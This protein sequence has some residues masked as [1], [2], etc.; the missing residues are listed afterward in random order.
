MQET[1]GILFQVNAGNTNLPRLTITLDCEVAIFAERYIILRDLIAF[2]Q[3]RVGIVLAVELRVGRDV[4]V[5]GKSR[6]D[7]IG[8]GLPVDDR[9]DARHAHTNR[10]Y[11]GIGGS[12]G[13]AC[14]ART[15]HFTFCQELR[16]YFKAYDNLEI[17]FNINIL[18]FSWHTTYLTLSIYTLCI[19]TKFC[20]KS[21]L[22][23]LIR[24]WLAL[25]AAP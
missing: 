3:V 11:V 4:A 10:A 17:C 5:K 25:A 2:H 24:Q 18:S 19:S 14:A 12:I 21:S 6:H 16:V 8:Y 7:G 13:I 15:K 22:F 20:R 1:C 23:C 9:Q